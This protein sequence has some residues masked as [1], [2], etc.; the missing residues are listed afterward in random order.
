MIY[1]VKVEVEPEIRDAYDAWL[2]GHAREV[3]NAGGFTKAEIFRESD[4]AL[5]WVV[6]YHAENMTVIENYVRHHAP[7]LR[8]DAV[9]RFGERAHTERRILVLESRVPDLT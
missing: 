3:V 1:E 5:T 2:T 7:N 8:A 4:G 6:H 9:Q